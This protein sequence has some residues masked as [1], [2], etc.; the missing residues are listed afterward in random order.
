LDFIAQEIDENSP[1]IG[2]V[3]LEISLFALC[4]FHGWKIRKSGMFIQLDFEI[5]SVYISHETRAIRAHFSRSP[6][7][8][9]GGIDRNV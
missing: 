2:T 5:D 8:H 3:N 7:R 4:G 6:F 9:N 1:D